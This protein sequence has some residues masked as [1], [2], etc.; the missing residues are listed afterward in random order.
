M[1]KPLKK[2]KTYLL[3]AFFLTLVLIARNL[4]F[5]KKIVSFFISN[6]SEFLLNP[7]KFVCDPYKKRLFIG[8]VVVAPERFEQRNVLR[9]FSL[10]KSS[11]VLKLNLNFR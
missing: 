5:K 9:E 4:N 2:T 7:N 3:I 11:M 6:S 1:L 10:T 8:I